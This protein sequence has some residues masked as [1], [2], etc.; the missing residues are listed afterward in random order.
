MSNKTRAIL[1]VAGV[2]IYFVS[3]LDFVPDFIPGLGQVDDLAVLFTGGK[4][5]WEFWKTPDPQAIDV[6]QESQPG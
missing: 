5:A 4:K 3:P 2:F 1:I 6:P